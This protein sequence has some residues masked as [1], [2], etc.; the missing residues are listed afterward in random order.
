MDVLTPAQRR[1]CMSNNRGTSTRPELILRRLLWQRGLRY[2]LKSQLP[3][4]PDIVF[5]GGKLAIFVDGCFWHQCPIH[6]TLPKTNRDFWQAKLSANVSRDRRVDASLRA[7]GWTVLRIWEHQISKHQ[8]DVVEE[9][10][11][12]LGRGWNGP[13]QSSKR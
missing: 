5:P 1:L 6:S 3:G 9:I 12:L 7:L 8:I 4:K 2:R 11:A 13:D 10:A